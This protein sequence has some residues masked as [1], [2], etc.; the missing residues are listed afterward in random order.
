MSSKENTEQEE[1]PNWSSL[2]KPFSDAVEIIVT[3]R[4]MLPLAVELIKLET[5]EELQTSRTE[6][7][8]DLTTFLAATT[9]ALTKL[10]PLVMKDEKITPETYQE[11]LNTSQVIGT[12]I[13][14]SVNKLTANL[15]WTEGA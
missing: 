13:E 2:R 8:K 4:N 7:V 9:E 3:A 1:A 14:N 10:K 15:G 5:N 11:F 6:L 12:I